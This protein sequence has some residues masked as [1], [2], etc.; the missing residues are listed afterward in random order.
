MEI[1]KVL[2]QD[3]EYQCDIDVSVEE[4][5]DILHDKTLMNENYIDAL[6]KFYS[7]PEHKSTCKT[8]GEKYGVSPESYNGS[9]SNFAQAVQ[10]KLNRFE[11]IGTDENPSYWIIPMLGK[12]IGEYIVWTLRPELVE[13]I[14]NT[15]FITNE[16]IGI[17]DFSNLIIRI[18]RDLGAFTDTFRYKRKELKGSKSASKKGIL[19]KYDKK[20]RDW[21]I[22]EGGGTEVQYHIFFRGNKIG[23]GL[24]FNTQYVPFATNKTSPIKLVQP[25]A[26]AFIST[27]KLDIVTNL[28]S[29]GFKYFGG[30][31]EEL[32]SLENN[33]YYLF[34]KEIDLINNGILKTDYYLM[35]S[36]LKNELFDLYCNIFTNRNSIETN[37]IKNMKYI[38]L[39]K[40]NKN[41]ILSGAPGTGKTYLAK[42]IALKMIFGKDS[43]KLLTDEE[44]E[45]FKECFC[46][47]QFHPSYDY[48]D[49]VEGLRPVK[50]DGSE[51]GFELKDGVFKLFC[52]KALKDEKH[53]FVIIIDEINRAE[54]S[55]VFGELFFS[56]DPGYRGVEG[57]IKTQYSNLQ[58]D[59]DT[60][61]D[62]FYIPENVY[63][64]GT[65]NDID[66]S[67]ESFDFAMRRR[68]AWKEIKAPSTKNG[69]SIPMW[70]VEIDGWKMSEDLKRE[71][72]K[73]I[74][75]LNNEIETIQGLSS[76]FH[77][78]PAYFLK[79]KNYDGDFEQLWENHLK[80][81]LFEYLRGLPKSETNLKELK[82]AY[83]ITK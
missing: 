78:G 41:L 75:A 83:D 72:K 50:K 3:G 53:N 80:G 21:A 29:I 17:S 45:L 19:F 55:K 16:I 70:D 32:K 23:F 18:N 27:L 10:K 76:A 59:S 28:K 2:L 26:D 4:W 15:D 82:N 24:G 6:F 71:A 66:R 25:F 51:L 64:I 48:T 40:S 47:V 68:F 14:I 31:E 38:E 61:K 49:F 7:E 54:I 39:L 44:K 1:K 56:I 30:F 42:Q 67:I 60:F 36:L 58:E 35:L 79:L 33:K 74:V 52:K 62:G 5:K 57:K 13:A 34:G 73:K 20:D 63:I 46:F 37:D 9:I 77:I 65:M 81:V 43:E 8:L 12:Y 22:N 11:I 69:D